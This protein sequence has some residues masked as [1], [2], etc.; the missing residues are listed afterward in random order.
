[1]DSNLYRPARDLNVVFPGD[2]AKA[3]QF[4]Q[5]PLAPLPAPAF[6]TDAVLA[7]TLLQASHNVRLKGTLSRSWE[8][9]QVPS[10]SSV[11]RRGPFAMARDVDGTAL[12]LPLQRGHLPEILVVENGGPHPVEPD[13]ML[14]TTVVPETF[15]ITV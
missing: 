7:R 5:A 12:F 14:S 10:P 4:G 1:M 9:A 8:D 2:T 6:G 11:G 3:A 15:G 13:E